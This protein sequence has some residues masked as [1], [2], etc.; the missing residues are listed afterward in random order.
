VEVG[1]TEVAADISIVVDYPEELQRVAGAV[2]AA[3]AEAIQDLV[4]MKVAEVNVTIVDVHIPG[5]DDTAE[6]EARVQ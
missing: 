4:G 1:E 5:D 2:R 6:Q 3:A